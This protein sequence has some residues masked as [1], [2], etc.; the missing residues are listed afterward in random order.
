MDNYKVEQI[1]VF[2]ENGYE[3]LAEVTS[4]LAE[5]GINIRSLSLADTAAY[6]ILRLIVN[7]AEKAKQVLK[8]GGFT[9]GRNEV[10]VIEVTDRPGGTASVLQTILDQGLHIEYMYAFAQ[11]NGERAL[12]IFRFA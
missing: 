2:L 5:N 7:D 11:G 3:R 4:L 1:A 12:I 9:V 8:E 10:L 6:A